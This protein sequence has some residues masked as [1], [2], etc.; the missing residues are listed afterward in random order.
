LRPALLPP[1]HRLVRSL[2]GMESGTAALSELTQRL[3]D[4]EECVV[5]LLRRRSGAE[6][7]RGWRAHPRSVPGPAIPLETVIKL[8]AKVCTWEPISIFVYRRGREDEIV[9]VENASVAFVIMDATTDAGVELSKS[10]DGSAPGQA[11]IVKTDAKG[12]AVVYV[13]A[14]ERGK[15]TISVV[16]GPDIK[17]EFD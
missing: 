1:F 15:A 6:G 10:P 4:L 5:E 14:A 7:R 13:H 11:R 12:E 17:V 8:E 9:L 16:A 2:A 3:N